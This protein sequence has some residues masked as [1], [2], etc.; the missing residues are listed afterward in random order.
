MKE[1]VSKWV[2]TIRIVLFVFLLFS[3]YLYL[4]RGY[5]NL[6]IINKVFGSTAVILS[7]F[8]LLIKPLS[9]KI[10]KLN[11][12]VNIRRHLG[13]S[14]LFMAMVHMI[15]PAILLPEKFPLSW[16]QN[17]ITPVIFGVLAIL[18]WIYLAYIS[19]NEKIRKMGLDVWR[20]HQSFLGKAAFLAILLHL[21]VMKYQ[22]WINWWNGKVKVSPELA[23]PSY[24]PASTFVLIFMLVVILCRIFHFIRSKNT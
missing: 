24:P 5:Y 12:Y 9:R 22:G 23:N 16:Y 11:Q 8:T 3:V 7:G 2:K 4:R 15:I 14:A 18:I 19:S 17:E 20:K 21:V 1:E 6:Y 10:E 13:L